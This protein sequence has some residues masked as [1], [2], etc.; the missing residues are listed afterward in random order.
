VGHDITAHLGPDD[1]SLRTEWL[2]R[3]LEGPEVSYLRRGA[4]D[5]LRHVIYEVM[6]AREC[7]GDVSGGPG[8]LWVTRE[9]L[10]AALAELERRR[11][12]GALVDEEIRFVGECLK[13]LS[14]G[15][16]R[17]YIYFG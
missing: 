15:R 14:A 17:V 11:R 6:D 5:P 13:A 7:D 3:E 2:A 8:T 12:E 4:N 16:D 1:P 9:E 10:G